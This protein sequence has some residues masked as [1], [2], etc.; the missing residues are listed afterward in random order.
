MAFVA[1]IGD[2]N[3]EGCL[4]EYAC[5]VGKRE[6]NKGKDKHIRRSNNTPN[7]N[8][9]NSNNQASSSFPTHSPTITTTT[10][11]QPIN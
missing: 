1:S 6:Q 9:S 11:T 8:S 2:L 3:G 5:K 7:P 4:E 10:N